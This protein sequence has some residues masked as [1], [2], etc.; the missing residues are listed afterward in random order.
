MAA[1]ALGG[2]WWLDDGVTRLPAALVATAESVAGVD[3]PP[4]LRPVP[5]PT[6]EVVALADEAHL[7]D[8]GRQLL[9]GAR[10]EL[11]GA[12]AFAGRCGGGHAVRP[13]EHEGA[14]GCYQPGDGSIVVYVD[15]GR[16]AARVRRR[17][18]RARDPARGLD[19]PDER[20]AGGGHP[21]AGGGGRWAR[22]RRPAARA[23]RR[24]GRAA[25]VGLFR[26]DCRTTNSVLRDYYEGYGFT[27]VGRTDF[28]A[29]SATLLELRL[30]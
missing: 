5:P 3:V 8:E 23:A 9:Y 16:A 7:T 6:A 27:A 29:F 24:E 22:P 18:R 19:P 14:V 11:L 30:R 15:D 13:P 21:S 20:R 2:A 26:L 4:A 10:P 28:P 17:G 1:V 12:S 25:G